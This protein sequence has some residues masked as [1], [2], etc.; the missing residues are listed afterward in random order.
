MCASNTGEYYESGREAFFQSAPIENPF[1]EDEESNTPTRNDS[2]QDCKICFSDSP[3]VRIL[4][5]LGLVRIQQ[6]IFGSTA[7]LRSQMRPQILHIMLESLSN[8]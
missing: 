2:E 3:E 7:T 5:K 4:N 1:A 8:G 6:S